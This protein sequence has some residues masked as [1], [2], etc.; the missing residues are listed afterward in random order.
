ME[1]PEIPLNF[2]CITGAKV[3]N[4]YY[5][6]AAHS[7]RISASARCFVIILPMVCIS[8]SVLKPP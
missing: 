4:V 5:A 8:F 1:I 2:M 6:T 3:F 7:D